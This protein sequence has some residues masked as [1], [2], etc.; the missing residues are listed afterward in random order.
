M[1]SH[2]WCRIAS[3]EQGSGAFTSIVLRMVRHHIHYSHRHIWVGDFLV[4]HIYLHFGRG[5]DNHPAVV[6]RKEH[7]RRVVVVKAALPAHA[8]IHPLA[9]HVVVAGSFFHS[10]GRSHHIDLLE[11]SVHADSPLENSCAGD[12]LDARKDRPVLVVRNDGGGCGIDNYHL[13]DV[14]A[15]SVIERCK[16]GR[17]TDV[18]GLD[19]PPGTHISNTVDGG[20][21]EVMRVKLLHRSVQVF[22]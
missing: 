16:R 19:G 20:T 6:C 12:D 4:C 1:T 21:L 13:W 8:H 2:T 11:A 18:P 10:Y 9:V 7:D 3:Q 15:G 14:L 5:P 22:G 17:P